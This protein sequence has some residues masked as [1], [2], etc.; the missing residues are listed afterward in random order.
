MVSTNI[1]RAY[2]QLVKNKKARTNA[3]KQY[4]QV[5]AENGKAYLFTTNDLEKRQRS[6]Q[7]KIQRMF[8]Q[9]S[10]LSQSQ[11]LL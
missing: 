1:Q 11:K 10:L 6:A 2:I 7:Q 5:F 3:S 9:L 8:I 4:F